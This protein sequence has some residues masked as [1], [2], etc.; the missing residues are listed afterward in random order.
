[1]KMGRGVEWALHCCLNLLWIG[2]DQ[3]VTATHLAAF[4]E[5]PTAY[6]NKQVQ[7]LVRAGI[8]TSVPG[9]NGGFRLARAPKDISLLDVVTAIEGPEP[10]FRCMEIRQQGPLGGAPES[11]TTQCLIDQAMRQAE[12]AWRRELA[13]RTLAD[14]NAAVERDVPAVPDRTRRWFASPRT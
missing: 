8:A 6:L 4:Y 10:A 13:S 3:A 14:L 12:L 5:L 9:P 2:P 7:A 11:F 1:M